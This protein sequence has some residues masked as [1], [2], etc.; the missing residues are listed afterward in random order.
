MTPIKSTLILA[1]AALLLSSGTVLADWDP[2]YSSDGTTIIN[3]K[4][5]YPQMPDPFGWDVNAS[6]PKVLADD[7]RCSETGPVSDIHFWGSWRFD[8]P[9]PIES[10]NLSIHSDV[11]AVPG[12]PN[13]YSH[14]GELL[15]ERKLLPGEWQERIWGTGDQGWYDPNTGEAVR[16]DHFITW[17]YNVVD[18]PD[19]FI[20][21][22]GQIYWLDVSVV[23]G[24]AGT[25]PRWG[26]K[27]SLDHFNDDATWTDYDLVPPQPWQELR[28]PL[29]GESLDLAFV[30][31][32][33]PTS[34]L[35]FALAGTVW[36]WRRRR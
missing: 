22:L 23:A 35:L 4:M 16:P 2:I 29:T 12:D 14:P 26:W 7:W 8:Q 19:P 28:D 6:Y 1:V 20:Q 25:E 3:H 10:I 21:E 13:S 34:A 18:I 9:I 27:T 36:L 11:P 32:P 30:I 31:T 24:P 17:Q 15:W 5:H 33:E